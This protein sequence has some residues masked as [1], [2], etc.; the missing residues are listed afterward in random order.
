MSDARYSE[1]IRQKVVT[2]LLAEKL[3]DY[4]YTDY[5]IFKIILS[6]GIPLKQLISM[7]VQDIAFSQDITYKVNSTSHTNKFAHIPAGLQND[8]CDHIDISS[9]DAPA[10]IDEKTGKRITE[11]CFRLHL[12]Q[13]S[14]KSKLF[15]EPGISV[16]AIRK[17]HLYNLAVR[18]FDA[19]MS[20]SGFRTRKKLL[21]YLGFSSVTYKTRRGK[22]NSIL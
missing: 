19:A 14:V 9:P 2:I 8:I 5:L 17:T 6:T 4:S 1:P 3:R 10:F 16:N 13:A 21:D 11:S 12:A 20:F 15:D 7:N 18:D 22:K